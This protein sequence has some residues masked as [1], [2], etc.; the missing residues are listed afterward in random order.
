LAGRTSRR[1]RRRRRPRS[2][3]FF[4]AVAPTRDEARTHAVAWRRSRPVHECGLVGAM[5]WRP[6]FCGE[7]LPC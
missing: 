5:G 1:R 7:H 4:R 3:H 6:S 2:K